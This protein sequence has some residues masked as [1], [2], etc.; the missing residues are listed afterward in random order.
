MEKELKEIASL[1][2]EFKVTEKKEEVVKDKNQ[3]KLSYKQQQAYDTLPDEIEALEE[4][5]A[6]INTC[7]YDPKCYEEKGLVSL[8]EELK[9]LEVEYE[10][11]TDAYLEVLEIYES[12]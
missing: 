12:L 10:E 11:K 7:L 6:E 9:H 8:S 2:Q 4:R 5:I 3:T 1:E